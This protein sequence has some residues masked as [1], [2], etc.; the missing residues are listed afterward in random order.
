M[1]LMVFH[2][3]V[4]LILVPCSNINTVTISVSRE[5]SATKSMIVLLPF[6]MEL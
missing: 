6:F 1:F 3:G 4:I 5:S 2:C